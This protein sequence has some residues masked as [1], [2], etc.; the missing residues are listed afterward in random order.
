MGGIH[1]G[2][3][4]IFSNLAFASSFTSK[5]FTLIVTLLFSVNI[6]MGDLYLLLKILTAFFYTCQ[7]SF[8][9][10]TS[11]TQKNGN[12]SE[13]SNTALNTVKPK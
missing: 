11:Y 2:T 1:T 13:R 9:F 3:G 7:I 12:R 8:S 5:A 6:E 4:P 10:D